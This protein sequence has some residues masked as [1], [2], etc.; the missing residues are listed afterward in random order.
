MNVLES[1]GIGGKEKHME[2]SAQCY[3]RRSEASEREK[4]T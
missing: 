4:K 1:S 2:K 3:E